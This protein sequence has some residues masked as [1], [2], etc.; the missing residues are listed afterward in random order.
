MF[1][2]ESVE[3]TFDYQIDIVKQTTSMG[4]MIDGL[5]LQSTVDYAD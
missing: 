1:S 3:L 4:G 5:V 2:G